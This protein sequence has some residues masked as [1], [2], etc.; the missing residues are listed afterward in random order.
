MLKNIV[1]T[2]YITLVNII[3]DKPIVPELIQSQFNKDNIKNELNI[4]IKSKNSLR[5]Q[6]KNFSKLENMLK[7]KNITPSVHATKII[8]NILNLN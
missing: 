7:N 6:L 4:L 2:K 3:F 8:K 5:L 1:F